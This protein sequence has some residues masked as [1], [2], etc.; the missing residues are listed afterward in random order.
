MEKDNLKA[1][2]KMLEEGIGT[3]LL[4]WVVPSPGFGSGEDTVM[5]RV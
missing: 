3:L 2:E 4:G 5:A 1:T